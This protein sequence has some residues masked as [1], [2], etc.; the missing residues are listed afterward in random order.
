MT[1]TI[2]QNVAVYGGLD[3]SLSEHAAIVTFVHKT[4]ASTMPGQLATINVRVFLDSH[5]ADRVLKF[6]PLVATRKEAIDLNARGM[7]YA[8]FL[9]D[10]S[11]EEEQ[12]FAPQPNPGMLVG[13]LPLVFN[14]NADEET[15]H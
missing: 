2:G 6:L 11:G 15:H 5:M 14:L 10:G 1:I 12:T 4:Q 7:G 13:G 9:V 8:A 3:N